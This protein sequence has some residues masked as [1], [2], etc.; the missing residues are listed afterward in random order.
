MQHILY[1]RYVYIYVYMIHPRMIIDGWFM[2]CLI[3]NSGGVGQTVRTV[4]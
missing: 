4:E 1:T 2:V 3:Q